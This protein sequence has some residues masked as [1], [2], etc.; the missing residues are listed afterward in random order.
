MCAFIIIRIFFLGVMI[1]AAV[2]VHAES[3]NLLEQMKAGG[4]ILMIRHAMAPGN[5]DPKNFQI[6]DCSTQRN[7]DDRGR[8]Q[9][10]AI[11]EWLRSNGI[12]KARMFSSQWCRCQETANLIN[13]GPVVQLPALNSFYERP[14]DREPNLKALR[15]FLSK[16]TSQEELLILVTHFVTISEISGEAVSSGEGVVLRIKEKG[17]FEVAGRLNFGYR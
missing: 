11:G 2:N 13:L 4:H 5:G 12:E 1:F 6:G 15:I 16:Q 3:K 17:G 7:L 14:Q 9:A 8:S 10:R